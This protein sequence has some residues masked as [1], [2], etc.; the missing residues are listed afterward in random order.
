M[1]FSLV[2]LSAQSL[3]KSRRA[4]AAHKVLFSAHSFFIRAMR[5]RLIIY[6]YSLYSQLT[7]CID[8]QWRVNAATN[9][10]LKVSKALPYVMCI[11][12]YSS[13]G[14]INAMTFIELN[15]ELTDIILY[16]WV[17]PL[18]DCKQPL[19]FFC[20]VTAGK[21]QARNEGVSP[22]RKDPG[23]KIRDRW[24]FC[25]VWGQRSCQG[26]LINQLN[27]SNLKRF[28]NRT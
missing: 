9:V 21:N 11:L 25:S 10:H 19:F 15:H 8:Q 27:P 26:N 16:Q 24:L 7:W 6:T 28:I 17:R 14:L 22:R 23:E 13:V 20:K 4:N 18:L 1:T 3:G 5:L 2:P 12:E